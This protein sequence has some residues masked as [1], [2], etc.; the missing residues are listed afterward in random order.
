MAIQEYD[1]LDKRIIELLSLSSHGSYRQLAIQLDVH[2][3]TLMQ[4]VKNLE[5]KGVIKGYRASIDYLKLGLEY[6]GLVNIYADNVTTVQD[7]I[8]AMPQVIAVFD[9]TGDADCVAWI[10]CF[11][12]EEFSGV[13]KRI[14]AIPDVKK[15]NTAVILDIKKDPFSYVPPITGAD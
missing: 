9:V 8:G 3:T 13:V 6:M 2:P 1:E 11:D 7:A 10:A 14:N 5:T 4:R 15:T 12:R